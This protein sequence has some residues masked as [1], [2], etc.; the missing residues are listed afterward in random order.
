MLADDLIEERVKGSELVK[1]ICDICRL[2]QDDEAACISTK[3]KGL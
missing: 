3:C 2:L 1:R